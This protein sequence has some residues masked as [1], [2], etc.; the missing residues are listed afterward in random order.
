MPAKVIGPLIDIHSNTHVFKAYVFKSLKFNQWKYSTISLLLNLISI[1]KM[2]SMPAKVIG[3]LIDIHSNTHVFKA[4]VF[5]SL[6]FN[7]WIYST[8]SLLLN[9]ISITKMLQ[10]MHESKGLTFLL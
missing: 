10:A 5:K 7:Q 1:T 2:K 4:Y 3:P 9:L 6:K 8:I